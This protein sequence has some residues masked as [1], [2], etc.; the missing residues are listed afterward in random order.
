MKRVNMVEHFICL[1]EDSTLKLVK[2]ILSREEG[3]EG[4]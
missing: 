4:E 3:S 1:Y 2:I